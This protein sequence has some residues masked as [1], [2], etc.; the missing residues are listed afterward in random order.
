M[1]NDIYD[2]LSLSHILWVTATQT[3]FQLHSTPSTWRL[4]VWLYIHWICQQG[5][6]I[7]ESKEAALLSKSIFRVFVYSAAARNIQFHLSN[8]VDA[9]WIYALHGDH[10]IRQRHFQKQ[11][12]IVFLL[13]AIA[14]LATVCECVSAPPY[15]RASH[16]RRFHRFH[17]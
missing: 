5:F 17:L 15:I 11:N 8:A 3:M 16:S 10:K 4:C 14:M 7:E 9:V 1:L 6:Q 13:L 2:A 12:A